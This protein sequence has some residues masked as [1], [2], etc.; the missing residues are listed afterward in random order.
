MIHVALIPRR[1]FYGMELNVKYNQVVC[2]LFKTHLLAATSPKSL[3]YGHRRYAWLQADV[4]SL[5]AG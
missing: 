3:C 2:L 5:I 1:W 4:L